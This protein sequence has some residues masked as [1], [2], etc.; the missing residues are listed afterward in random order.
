MPTALQQ[1]ISTKLTTQFA[2]LTFPLIHPEKDDFTLT[3][4]F[5]QLHRWKEGQKANFVSQ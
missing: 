5:F 2:E 3:F 4:I 1:Q